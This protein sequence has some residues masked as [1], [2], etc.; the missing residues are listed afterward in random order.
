MYVKS[1][2]LCSILEKELAEPSVTQ[3]RILSTPL[4]DP[5]SSTVRISGT[6]TSKS[7]RTFW[8]K[9]SIFIQIDIQTYNHWLSACPFTIK[10]SSVFAASPGLS[11][12]AAC[13][14][15][16]TPRLALDDCA[17]QLRC[18]STFL[19]QRCQFSKR[20]SFLLL[21]MLNGGKND[22]VNK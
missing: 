17:P 9:K 13:P 4:P 2:T 14:P 15:C 19:W 11:K 20:F 6:C 7:E 18:V 1:E 10:E 16:G 3:V 5:N 21:S 22:S 12:H 8:C